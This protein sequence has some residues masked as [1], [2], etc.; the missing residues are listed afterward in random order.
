MASFA[1]EHPMLAAN[2]GVGGPLLK[3][4]TGHGP[5]V[6]LTKKSF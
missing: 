2:M 6:L 4:A 5:Q 1:L 3:G